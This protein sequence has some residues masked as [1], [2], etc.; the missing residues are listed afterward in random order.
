MSNDEI[1]KFVREAR[2]DWDLERVRNIYKF[3]FFFTGLMFA[4][5]S[6]AM[7]FPVRSACLIL[8]VAESFSWIIFLATGICALYVCG[9]FVTR[10]TDPV[11]KKRDERL[12][13]VRFWMWL[14]FIIAFVVLAAVKV[15]DLTYVVPR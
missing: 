11:L 2:K 14:F 6:F 8:R 12:P 9:G 4:I 13:M 5:V 10:H 7:Q 15:I 1:D 3:D